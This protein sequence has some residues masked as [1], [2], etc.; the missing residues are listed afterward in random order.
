MSRSQTK[1]L[2][3]ALVNLIAA[4]S[5]AQP[6]ADVG[7]AEADCADARS[8]EQDDYAEPPASRLSIDLSLR[9]ASDYF[10][11]GI[12][13]KT[14]S[15]NLQPSVEL[16]FTLATGE[17]FSLSLIV[18]TWSSFSD[19]RATGASGSFS[20]SWYEHDAYVGLSVNTD[21]LTLDAIY[22][23]YA[24]P[25]SDFTE[26]EDL[27]FSLSFDDSEVWDDEGRFAVNPG[28]SVAFETRNAALGTDSGVWL[29]LGIEPEIDL[30]ASPFG[31]TTLSFPIGVGLSLDEYYQRADGTSET[32]GYAEV[33][34]KL[35]FDLSGSLGTVAPALDV[36]VSYLFLDGALDALN[37]GDSG[38]LVF[39]TGLSWSF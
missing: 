14:D 20:E 38:E 5:S 36:G 8:P 28:V 39:S 34:A 1:L 11:R 4:T 37:G 26:Y 10:F 32:F 27:T 33:G 16:R 2:A 25:S 22:T 30:G 35:S 3:I 29:G 19:D 23:W 13:Q 9:Y 12:L 6:D 24:S 31:P 18:G 17:D 7:V 15:F 21:R